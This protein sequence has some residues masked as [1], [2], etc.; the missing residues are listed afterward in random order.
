M[1][2]EYPY[3]GPHCLDQ[4]TAVL[5]YTLPEASV[6]PAYP[7]QHG[8]FGPSLPSRKLR[9]GR[10]EKTMLRQRPSVYTWAGVW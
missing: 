9:E 10:A 1:N 6:L 8:F 5:S 4:K 3:S 2:E 7:P